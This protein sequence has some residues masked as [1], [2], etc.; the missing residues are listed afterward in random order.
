M[1][2]LPGLL[3]LSLVMFS[4]KQKEETK[5]FLAAN[6]DTTVKPS[7]N[8]FLYA[9]GKWLKD[10]PIPAD[11]SG[12]GI[13]NL[14]QEEIYTRLKTINE[15]AIAENAAK[16]TVSQKIADFWKSGMDTAGI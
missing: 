1:K 6:I 4:C 9:N 11:E 8:F 14:V 2:K 16:G 7:D 12:W 3:I 13:G 15:K 10:N 5:D